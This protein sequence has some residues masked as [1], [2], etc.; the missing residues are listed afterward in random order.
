MED[1][2]GSGPVA[3]VVVRERPPPYKDRFPKRRRSMLVEAPGVL[4]S[5]ERGG[6]GVPE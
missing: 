2:G 3:E 1:H 6:D 4:T 5:G